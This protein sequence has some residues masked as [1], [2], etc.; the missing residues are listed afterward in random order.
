MSLEFIDAGIMYDD[1]KDEFLID[2]HEYCE[3]YG[4]PTH[5]ASRRRQWRHILKALSSSFPDSTFTKKRATDGNV[6]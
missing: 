5:R 4:L 3:F 1:S 2:T 6:S